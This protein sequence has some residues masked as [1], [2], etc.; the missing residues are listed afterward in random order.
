M[1]SQSRSELG[2]AHR[3]LGVHPDEVVAVATGLVGAWDEHVAT[4]PQ[5]Q[6]GG[7]LPDVGVQP[8]AHHLPVLVEVGSRQPLA[9]PV[10]LRFKL[11]TVLE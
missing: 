9:L 8:A 1:T 6:R 5:L 3:L 4:G 7:D 2:D 10:L 11:F